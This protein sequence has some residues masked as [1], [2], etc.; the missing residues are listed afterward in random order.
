VEKGPK[1]QCTG[2]GGEQYYGYVDEKMG[3]DDFW[4]EDMLC[5]ILSFCWKSLEA[6]GKIEDAEQPEK[7]GDPVWSANWTRMF[8]HPP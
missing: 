7:Q 6:E 1:H 2:A 4:S 8:V 3:V 5:M